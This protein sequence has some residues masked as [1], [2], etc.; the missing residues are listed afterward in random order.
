MVMG[1]TPL[2]LRHLWAV[3]GDF[4]FFSGF[5]R[6]V[7]HSWVFVGDFW[8]LWTISVA[9]ARHFGYLPCFLGM[10]PSRRCQKSA[11]KR[12]FLCG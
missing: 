2:C 6:F 1:F 10:Q 9:D 11:V 7:R 3:V 4:L 12:G 5:S 8:H